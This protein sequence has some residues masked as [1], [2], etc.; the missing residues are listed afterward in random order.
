M[1]RMLMKFTMEILHI[2]KKPNK[3]L[4]QAG[5][6]LRCACVSEFVCEFVFVFMC[7]YV[8]MCVCELNVVRA[9][10]VHVCVFVCLCACVV[11]THMYLKAHTMTKKRRY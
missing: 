8:S 4:R 11:C 1:G 7:V 2:K 5:N 6:N 9:R 3:P 10:V